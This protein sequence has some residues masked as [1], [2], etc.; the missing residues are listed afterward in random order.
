[1]LVFEEGTLATRVVIVVL[2]TVGVAATVWYQGRLWKNG[3]RLWHGAA[4][5]LVGGIVVAFVTLD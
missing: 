2:V 4:L 1:M 5:G 3:L